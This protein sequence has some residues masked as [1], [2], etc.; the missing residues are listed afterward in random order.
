MEPEGLLPCK[1]WRS[2]GGDYEKFSLLE[3]KVV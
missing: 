1:V 3:Y 2:N